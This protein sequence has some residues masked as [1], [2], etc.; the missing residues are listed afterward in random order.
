[1]KICPRANIQ[2]GILDFVIIRE[3]PK[4]HIPFFLLKLRTGKVHLSKYVEIIKSKTMQIKAN[5][6]LL[7][8]DREPYNTSNTITIKL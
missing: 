3:F 6:T 4:L 5:N 2:D 8:V 1:M 7:H